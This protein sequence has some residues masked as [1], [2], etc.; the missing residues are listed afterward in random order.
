MTVGLINWVV[1]SMLAVL[2]PFYISMTDINHNA[3]NKTLE[4][5]VRIFAD[6]FENTL[7][8]KCNCKV[9]LTK[10]TDKAAMEKLVSGYITSRLNLKVDG[11]PVALQFAGFSEEDGSIWNFFE[12]KNVGSI[13][14]LELFNNLLHDYSE[15]QVNMVHIK[16]NGKQKTEKLDHPKNTYTTSW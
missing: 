10:P 12:V 11:Q 15:Q 7:R 16:A 1:G 9:E 13:R 6:D 14:K 2:H 5:S 8:K 3:S 4:I